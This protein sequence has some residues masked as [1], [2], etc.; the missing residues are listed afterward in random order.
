MLQVLASLWRRHSNA[1][2]VASRGRRGGDDERTAPSVDDAGQIQTA[3]AER[4]T[5]GKVLLFP[6]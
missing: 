4:R 5:A 3:D 2:H 1:D 6:F